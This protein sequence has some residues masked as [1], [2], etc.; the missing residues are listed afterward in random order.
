MEMEATNSIDDVASQKEPE[1][2]IESEEF[3]L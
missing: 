1:I 3:V 2:A